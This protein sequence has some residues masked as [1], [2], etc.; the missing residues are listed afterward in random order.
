MA[1]H[2]V[3]DGQW[4]EF[5]AL[6]DHDPLHGRLDDN[7][8]ARSW[9]ST[10][11][12]TLRWYWHNPARTALKLTEHL[13]TSY[14]GLSLALSSGWFRKWLI[15]CYL[16]NRNRLPAGTRPNLFGFTRQITVLGQTC[17]AIVRDL[18]VLGQTGTMPSLAEYMLGHFTRMTRLK[19]K[20]VALIGTLLIMALMI[21]GL[22]ELAHMPYRPPHDMST[23]LGGPE[24]RIVWMLI[25]LLAIV[26]LAVLIWF[27]FTFVR[28]TP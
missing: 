11:C 20:R 7:G 15:R 8:W 4:E 1:R 23:F 3:R 16:E 9:Q 19:A 2:G 26:W 24:L 10:T 28:K 17:W 6:I 25:A 14:R 5:S 22:Y 13:D 12:Q 27:V 21:L 18:G